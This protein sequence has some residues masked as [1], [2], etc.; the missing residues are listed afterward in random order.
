MARTWAKIYKQAVNSDNLNKLLEAE[1]LAEA[2][3]WRLL[4]TCTAYGRSPAT[5]ETFKARVCPWANI[6]IDQI[7]HA[8]DALEEHGLIRRYTVNPGTYLE[9]I[10]WFQF[11]SVNWMFMD[12]PEL[13]PPPDWDPPQ[14]LLDFLEEH[15]DKA[16]VTPERYGISTTVGTIVDTIVG[17]NGGTEGGTTSREGEGEGEVEGDID[18]ARVGSDAPRSKPR[19]LTPQQKAIEDLWHAFGFDGKPSGK[20]YSGIAKLVAEHGI[21]M[22]K[23]YTAFIKRAPPK[24]PEGA[25]PWAWFKQQFRAAMKRPWEW[26]RKQGKTG[27]TLPARGDADYGEPGK[28]EL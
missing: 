17:T 16:N 27:K 12:K 4:A 28:I 13:P 7:A 26:Q 14:S 25:E 20:G 11:Q 3:Y 21:P 6:S 22:V 9:V 15:A 5:P 24:L 10:N 23:Q 2:L 1:P 19:K 18:K 8:L